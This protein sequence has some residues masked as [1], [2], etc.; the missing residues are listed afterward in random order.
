MT[1]RQF[2]SQLTMSATRSIQV[3][4]LAAPRAECAL[5]SEAMLPAGARLNKVFDW[6]RSLPWLSGLAPPTKV[7]VLYVPTSIPHF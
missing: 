1:I 4:L 7:A 3:G 6:G 2:A 5:G